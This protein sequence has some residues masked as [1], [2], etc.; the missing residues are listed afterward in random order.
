MHAIA[1]MLR[2][3]GRQA[4]RQDKSA[5]SAFPERESH[6]TGAATGLCAAAFCMPKGNG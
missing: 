3:A 2:Q 1:S 6:R 4:G 5:L